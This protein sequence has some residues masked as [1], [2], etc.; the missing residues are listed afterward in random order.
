MASLLIPDQV[1]RS[2][3]Y[4]AENSATFLF[5]SVS[6]RKNVEN[7]KEKQEWGANTK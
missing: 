3:V 1:Q 6:S 2:A 5:C 4:A 7:T